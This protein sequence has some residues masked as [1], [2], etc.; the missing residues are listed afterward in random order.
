MRFTLLLLISVL[1][2]AALFSN[3]YAQTAQEWIDRGYDA[4]LSGNIEEAISCYTKALQIDPQNKYAYHV[5]AVIKMET[6]D[7]KGALSD[8]NKAIEISPNFTEAYIGRGRTK[9]R[10][11]DAKGA[12]ADFEKAEDLRKRGVDH[13]LEDI[14][15][16]IE[17][18]PKAAKKI[19]DRGTYK[20]LERDYKGA[21]KDF[22]RY[23]ELVGRPKNSGVYHSKARALQELGDIQ[24]AIDT[25]SLIINVFP[26]DLRAYELRA[27]LREKIGDKAGAISDLSTMQEMIR[28]KKRQQIDQK[29]QTIK[30]NPNSYY[31]YKRRAELR[32]ELGEYEAALDD[33]EKAI[34][35]APDDK[36]L[37][38]MKSKKD[39]ILREMHKKKEEQ[40]KR[41][42]IDELNKYIE[43]HPDSFS[44]YKD[45]AKLKIQ[46][47]E[48]EAA[49]GDIEKAM[50]LNPDDRE[51]QLMK[52]TVLL[53]INTKKKV[54]ERM[55][56]SQ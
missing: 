32:A 27:S 19:L 48:N 43:K 40:Q 17:A 36:F 16:E 1:L 13:A 44:S 6:G 21:V 22:N 2:V 10:M 47:G 38:G 55:R 7:L 51:L 3:A 11:G 54:L 25:Y 53:R 18:D 34:E 8:Y 23:L 31:A 46:L 45:R 29:N 30:K 20:L 49:L 12:K 35:L 9:E 28:E 50:D 14:D 52:E 5:R 42:K 4:S 15:K 33:M 56:K 39:S 37:L 41:D 24:G 26:I